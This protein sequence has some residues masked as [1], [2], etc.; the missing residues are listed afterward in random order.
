VSA[1][2]TFDH[3]LI[4]ARS[5]AIGEEYVVFLVLRSFSERDTDPSIDF[6]RLL[7]GSK[8]RVSTSPSLRSLEAL[9]VDHLSPLVT[10]RD[11][12]R[13]PTLMGSLLSS[14]SSLDFPSFG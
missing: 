1:A 5:K 13:I 10:G 3:D 9:S 8:E 4:Y 7:P 2:A 6:P 11:S 14:R 12:L